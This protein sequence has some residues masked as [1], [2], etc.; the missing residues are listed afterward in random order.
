MDAATRIG[1]AVADAQRDGCTQPE[2]VAVLLSFA[3]GYALAIG[4]SRSTVECAQ[5]DA[6]ELHCVRRE[7]AR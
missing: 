6:L 7:A 4:W 5:R 2:L 3:A 1:A